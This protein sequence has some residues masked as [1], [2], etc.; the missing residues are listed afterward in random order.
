MGICGSCF[1]SSADDCTNNERSPLHSPKTYAL[2]QQDRAVTAWS[3]CPAR[4]EGG[5]FTDAQS[6]EPFTLSCEGRTPS[7]SVKAVEPLHY[8]EDSVIALSASATAPHAP[9]PLSAV[10]SANYHQL[11]IMLG[12]DSVDA[13]RLI[14]ARRAAKGFDTLDD[15]LAVSD[16]TDDGRHK[17]EQK[18]CVHAGCVEVYCPSSV[19]EGTVCGAVGGTQSV[20]GESLLRVAT[21]NLQQFTDVKA[22]SQ[23]L[24]EAV[25]DVVISS[26]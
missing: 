23:P 5:A 3:Q 25:C 17:I 20:E 14:D 22:A 12:I 18:L 16:I 7:S 2:Y 11:S 21:W 15:L 10:N 4:E 13:R 19:T 6:Q 8:R 9:L 24:V 1:H 26:G